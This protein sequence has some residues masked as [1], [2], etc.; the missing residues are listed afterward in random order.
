MFKAN[1]V[2]AKPCVGIC[3]SVTAIF[4]LSSTKTSSLK[5]LYSIPIFSASVAVTLS[6]VIINA[7]APAVI[8]TPM[9]SN[10]SEETLKYM[11]SRIPLGRTGQASE[12]AEIIAAAVQAVVEASP[13]VVIDAAAIT[14]AIMEAV[15]DMPAPAPEVAAEAAAAVAEVIAAATGEV[16]APEVQQQVADAVATPS[17]A[18]LDAIEYRLYVAEAKVDSLLGK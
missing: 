8:S 10:T 1:L 18:A 13:E 5:T 15:A 7:L 11:I 4:L 16:V 14:A 17:D 9:N 12:V 6:P 3:E 2:N